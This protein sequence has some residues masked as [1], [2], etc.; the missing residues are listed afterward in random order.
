[1]NGMKKQWLLCLILPLILLS[2]CSLTL[3][4]AT[5]AVEVPTILQVQRVNTETENHYLPFAPRTI[6]NQQTVQHLYNAM[7]AL[8]QF[9]SP[10]SPG[11]LSCPRDTYVKYQLVFLHDHSIIQK[12]L[13]DPSGCPRI[14]IGQNDVRATDK[15]F[16]RLFAL[17]IGIPESDL[18]PQPLF[19]CN[20]R[21][22]CPSP[23]P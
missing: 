15:S 22:P 9:S 2:G 1:M 4:S 10:D 12:A 16:A 13:Y 17:T 20:F 5:N 23:T 6:T 7:E 19:Y 11:S 3:T 18:A 8:P 14:W 21:T